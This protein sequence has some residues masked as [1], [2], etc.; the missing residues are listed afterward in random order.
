MSK[1]LISFCVIT[2]KADLEI[3]KKC[4]ESIA[5]C[6]LDN[7]DFEI[8]LHSDGDDDA[9]TKKIKELISSI[10]TKYNTNIIF[11]H[12]ESNIGI[13]ESRRKCVGAAHG[14]Y[15]FHVDGDDYV[16]E[17]A[18]K[19]I[20][21]R[22]DELCGWD[23]VQLGYKMIADPDDRD[24]NFVNN[25]IY[26]FVPEFKSDTNMLCDLLHDKVYADK[27]ASAHKWSYLWGIWSKLISKKV[28]DEMYKVVPHVYCN[29]LEDHLGLYLIAAYSKSYKC[30]F[31]IDVYRYIA[32]NESITHGKHKMNLGKWKST[33]SMHNCR[34]A[35]KSCEIITCDADVWK[36]IKDRCEMIE[37]EFFEKMIYFYDDWFEP[38]VNKIDVI[39]SFIDAF[40]L[41]DYNRLTVYFAKRHA[42]D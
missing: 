33:I 41:E 23:I 18:F 37:A 21:E 39:N 16:V 38:S 15:I 20:R 24:A 25:E 9:L 2:Y 3:T 36:D 6:G 35:L 11:I 14:E 40:G 31:D 4:L 8:I 12:S 28:C 26:R 32:N 7:D 10:Q 34:D 19:Q 42:N 29:L 13:F 17:G 1:I 27:E 5:K 22:Y 30:V